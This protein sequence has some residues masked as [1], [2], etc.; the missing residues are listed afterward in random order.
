MGDIK[1]GVGAV[2]N[3]TRVGV[4]ADFEHGTNIGVQA[5]V[6]PLTSQEQRDLATQQRLDDDRLI[7]NVG[8]MRVIETMGHIHSPDGETSIPTPLKF[9]RIRNKNLG[10]DVQCHI[11]SLG[12]SSETT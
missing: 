10:V 1:V 12:F 5:D 3:S 9:H 2:E 8:D 6:A 4:R 7:P 11:P